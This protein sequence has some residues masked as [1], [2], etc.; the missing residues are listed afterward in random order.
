[1]LPREEAKRDVR[2]LSAKEGGQIITGAKEPY[3]TMF[4]VLG[5]TAAGLV[6]CWA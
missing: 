3:A 6:K 1:M 2:F 5:M 4:A